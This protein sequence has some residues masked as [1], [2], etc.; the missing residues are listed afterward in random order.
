MSAEIKVHL[1]TYRRNALLPRALDSLLRQTCT[2]WVCEL[3]NDDPADPFPGELVRRTGDPRIT[4]VHHDRN[5][6]PTATFN[7]AFRRTPEP[8]VSV[9]EDDNWWEPRLLE[10]L[11]D[12]LVATPNASM[13]WANMWLWREGD[14]NTWV[15]A[16]TIWPSENGEVT[17]FA[18]PHPR[19]VC[20]ALHSIGA[21]LVRMNGMAYTIPDSV[22]S[23]AIEPVRERLFALPLI[24]VNEPLA[25]FALTLQTSRSESADDN[26]RV[27]TLLAKSWLS[28]HQLDRDFT[29]RVWEEC[30]GS[31]GHKHRALMA[32]AL[33]AGRVSPMLAGASASDLILVAGWIAR[34]P[35]RFSRLVRARNRFSDLSDFLESA[36]APKPS[37]GVDAE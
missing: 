30:R 23:F 15:K 32:A 24:R 31:R 20:G 33:N 5:L 25:N 17:T 11:L 22:P 28:H 13:A 4:Y 26:L 19:Q 10:A 34:H 18:V 1:L 27:L 21:M 35:I 2:N 7:L 9:L 37:V 36:E 3:H 14:D 16:G 6:G 12:A 8:F 29:K